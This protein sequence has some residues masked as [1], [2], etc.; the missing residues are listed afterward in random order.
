[1]RICVVVPSE[2]Y[3]QQAGVRIRY[4]RIREFLLELGNELTLQVLDKFSPKESPDKDVYIFSKCYDA[5][6]YVFARFLADAGKLIGV[7]IFDDYFSQ[8]SDSRFERM[9]EW[10][11]TVAE[12]TDFFLCSTPRMEEV[13]KSVTPGIPIHVMH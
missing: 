13:L 12:L 2:E 8:Q 1:M 11:R 9:R 10:L 6:A 5:R 7:D 4:L 3:L